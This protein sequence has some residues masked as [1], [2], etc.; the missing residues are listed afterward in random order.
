MPM[1]HSPTPSPPPSTPTRKAIDDGTTTF[2]TAT[3]GSTQPAVDSARHCALAA[4]DEL[5]AART[6]LLAA[7]RVFD[8]YC[9]QIA[10]H[11]ITDDTTISNQPTRH[12]EPPPHGTARPTDR[13]DTP[14][15]RYAAEIGGLQRGGAKISPDR[16]VR[17][18]RHQH[19][20]L[21]WLEE[22]HV[23]RSGKAHR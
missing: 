8:A 10:G 22:G 16:V 11:G 3:T 6:A 15:E 20:H 2:D 12:P 1:P 9:H 17:V 23:D 4:T 7:Q 14:A 18:A 21:V 13:P 19:G 5:H